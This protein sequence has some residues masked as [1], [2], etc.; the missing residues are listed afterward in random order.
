MHRKTKPPLKDA[1]I[2]YNGADEEW[3]KA[4]AERIERETIDGT[5][6]GAKLSTFFA[7][8]DIEYGPNFINRLNEGLRDARFFAPVLS[9]EFFDSGWANFEWTDQVALDPTN[10]AGRIIPLLLREVSKNGNRRIEF[11]APFTTL[12]RID[13]RRGEDFEAQFAE[14]IRILRG[15]PKERGAAGAPTLMQ[16]PASQLSSAAH[17]YAFPSAVP[18]LLVSNLLKLEGIPSVIWSGETTA[19]KPS[20]I[21][22]NIQTSDGFI[23]REK[24]LYTFANLTDELCPLRNG[25][26][27]AS[28]GKPEDSSAWLGNADKRRYLIALLNDCVKQHAR[29]RRIGKDEKGRFY[30]WPLL[31]R[32]D[33]SEDAPTPQTRYYELPG[34]TKLRAVAA[35]K[36]N[37]A[38]NST[39]WVH[40]AARIKVEL[41]NT[42]FFLCLEP[43]YI[44]T[45]DGREPLDGKSAGRLSIQ[46]SGKQQNPDV[47][48]AILFWSHVL[49]D[50]RPQIRIAVGSGRLTASVAPA[51]ASTSFGIAGDYIRIAALVQDF[52]TTLDQIVAEA[53]VV[54]RSEEDETPASETE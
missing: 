3:A 34:D 37:P 36:I 11:P 46:W 10:A 31:D 27:A 15:S 50:G 38:D 48:R 42:T 6:T 17:A 16:P 30:F 29:E 19:R 22:G 44:F 40:Y 4:L 45:R 23:L 24:R 33:A 20:E 32:G 8:W 18:E 12:N 21:W 13:F 5:L 53:E 49:S 43:T 26:D 54:E 35:K 25:V 28:I 7:P 51:L 52:D 9:P 39:F 47:L 14:L 2:S 41:F 1:F